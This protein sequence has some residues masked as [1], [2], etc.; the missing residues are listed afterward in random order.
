MIK[1]EFLALVATYGEENLVCIT[2]DNEHREFFLDEDE[3][4]DPSCIKTIGGL[5]II[6]MGHEKF[7]NKKTGKADIDCTVV[8]PLST[9]QCLAFCPS[10]QKKDIDRRTM[11]K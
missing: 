2:F 7:C 10:T 1:S 9:V 11:F 8:H 5:D 6:E 4:F 3:A